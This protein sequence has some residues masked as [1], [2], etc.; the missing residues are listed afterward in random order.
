MLLAKPLCYCLTS[1]ILTSVRATWDLVIVL[2]A[3]FCCKWSSVLSSCQTVMVMHSLF[4][5]VIQ[6]LDRLPTYFEKRDKMCW[7]DAQ[8]HDRRWDKIWCDATQLRCDRCDKD[9]VRQSRDEMRWDACYLAPLYSTCDAIRCLHLASMWPRWD[10]MHC[11]LPRSHVVKMRCAAQ[12]A[13]SLLC[14]Q[15]SMRCATCYLTPMSALNV[16]HTIFCYT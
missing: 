16:L 11:L 4:C 8:R 3:T 6:P 13:L 10:A 5:D 14:D 7:C 1:H 9:E 12:P 2:H 15:D